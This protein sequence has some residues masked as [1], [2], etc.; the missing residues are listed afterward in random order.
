M[1]ILKLAAESDYGMLMGKLTG[2]AQI[3]SIF[4]C[5]TQ[6]ICKEAKAVLQSILI[7]AIK[8]GDSQSPDTTVLSPRQLQIPYK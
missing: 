7:I 8:T 6:A 1:L 3:N 5:Y 2:A 4:G